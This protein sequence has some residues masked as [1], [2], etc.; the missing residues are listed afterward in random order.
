[1]IL[2]IAYLSRSTLPSRTANSIHVMKMCQ[3]F[4]QNGH[5]V[6]LFA[7][8]PNGYSENIYSYYGVEKCFGLATHMLSDAIP[9]SSKAYTT[10]VL[11]G[12]ENSLPDLFYGRDLQGLL[13]AAPLGRPL[14]LEAHR[15]PKSAGHLH[16]INDLLSCNNF[17]RLVV[18]SASLRNEYLKLLPTLPENRIIVAPDGADLPQN[19]GSCKIKLHGENTGIKVGYIGHLYEGKGMEMI[20]QLAVK[21]PNIDFHIIGGTEEDINYWK[22]SV[23]KT[24]NIIFYGYLPHGQLAP[25]YSAFD[26]MLAPY[27]HKVTFYQNTENISPWMSPLKI[28][29]YMA[30]SKAII[31]SDLPVLREV[32]EHEVNCLL[33]PPTNVDA[34]VNALLKLK[35]SKELREHLEITSHKIF[36]NKYTWKQRAK[37]VIK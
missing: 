23:K 26:I 4:V 11:E 22:S 7:S 12:W 6:V 25:Y 21:L 28:F 15:P 33:C 1:M 29:E 13:Y 36:V 30:Y 37:K 16:A 24:D 18:I 34:W 3:A 35:N 31:A 14:I 9:G 2:K 19:D 10:S 32:L 17:K 8:I 27:Q 20:S 5:Q